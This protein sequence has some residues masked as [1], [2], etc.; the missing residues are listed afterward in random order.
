[1]SWPSRSP[2]RTAPA[3]LWT[4]SPVCEPPMSN[5]P[6]AG[7]ALDVLG[8]VSRHTEPMPAA[9]IA[10]RLG[11]PRSSTYHLLGVLQEHGYVVHFPEERRYGLGVAAFELGS[12]YSRQAPLQRLARAAPPALRV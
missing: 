3:P 7:Q 11:L 1:V 5:A 12:A 4:P 2:R 8:L 10:Q 9:A 6:A